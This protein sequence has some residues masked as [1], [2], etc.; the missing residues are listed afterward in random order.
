MVSEHARWWID[1]LRRPLSH[2]PSPESGGLG[3]AVLLYLVVLAVTVVVVGVG[4]FLTVRVAR[5]GRLFGV[6]LDDRQRRLFRVAAASL[7]L[8]VATVVLGFGRIAS[9]LRALLFVVGVGARCGG[10][11]W[12]LRDRVRGQA[13][14]S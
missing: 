8:S 10:V 1:S 4:A 3:A 7:V 13:S 9:A 11:V 2:T 14:E 6:D 5:R 12:A